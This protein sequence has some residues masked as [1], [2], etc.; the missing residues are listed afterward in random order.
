MNK[1]P[2]E[3]EP[4]LTEE[5]TSSP[6]LPPELRVVGLFGEVSEKKA[7]DI[8]YALLLL[9]NEGDE[10]VDLYLSSTGGAAIDMF[11]IYDVMRTVRKKIDIN[12]I[13][14]GKVMSAAVILLAAGTKGKRKIGENCRVMLHSVIAGNQGTLHDMDNEM[15]EIKHTQE[16][17]IEVLC[18]ETNL[19]RPQIK[20]LL[21]KNVNTYFSAEDAVKYGIADEVI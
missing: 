9:V 13:G 2:E 20:K 18:K 21:A 12:T 16:Q 3:I 11:A 14:V 8:I 5:E 1:P 10:D 17:Y 4:E 6:L 19:T 7:E 15:K